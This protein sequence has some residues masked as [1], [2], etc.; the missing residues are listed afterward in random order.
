[1]FKLPA[2]RGSPFTEIDRFDWKVND[3]DG[4]IASFRPKK[5]YLPI[6]IMAFALRLYSSG[7]GISYNSI[8]IFMAHLGGSTFS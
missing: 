5:I 2:Q 6:M 7:F 1:M 3:G 4:R 8:F